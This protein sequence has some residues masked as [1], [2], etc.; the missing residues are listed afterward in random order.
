MPVA[1]EPQISETPARTV[2]RDQRGKVWVYLEEDGLKWE[3]CLERSEAEDLK[4]KLEAALDPDTRP[5]FLDDEPPKRN[6]D[7]HD[8]PDPIVSEGSTRVKVLIHPEGRTRVIFA[9][10][11]KQVER[12]IGYLSAWR[13][14]R[15]KGEKRV[16][17][18]P[19][20]NAPALPKRNGKANPS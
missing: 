5:T 9:W 18:E 19:H 16:L 14:K 6:K 2:F 1:N 7:D 8:L 17:N 11:G 4:Q 15:L 10:T 3:Q 20:R 13:E 12:V